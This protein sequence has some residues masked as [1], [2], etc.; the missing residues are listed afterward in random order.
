MIVLV[1][2]RDLPGVSKGTI[3]SILREFSECLKDFQE[4]LRDL[5]IVS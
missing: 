3:W 4:F 2:L 5:F 1:S